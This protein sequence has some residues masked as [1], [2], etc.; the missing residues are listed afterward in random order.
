MRT[1]QRGQRYLGMLMWLA[2]KLVFKI[3]V[4]HISGKLP[5]V[6]ELGEE[7]FFGHGAFDV[8]GAVEVAELTTSRTERQEILFLSA[9]LID[10]QLIT[11]PYV[12][13]ITRKEHLHIVSVCL[14]YIHASFSI[15]QHSCSSKIM[16]LIIIESPILIRAF[17][18][19]DH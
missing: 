6:A 16:A 15:H 11:I 17:F 3:M 10:K 7:G 13:C 4:E 19:S 5:D 14:S 8:V 2:F 18:H 12:T 1:E 9:G